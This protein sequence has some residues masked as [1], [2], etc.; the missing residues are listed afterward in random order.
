MSP[1]Q[2]SVFTSPAVPMQSPDGQPAGTW[3]PIACTLI[4]GPQSAVL[5]NT[6]FTTAETASLADWIVRTIPDKT[7]TS[8]YISHGFGD[9][10]LGLPTMRRRFPG[11]KVY[12][13]RLTLELMKR[14]ME[15]QAFSSFVGGFPGLI[16]EQPSTAEL[17]EVLPANNEIN[18]DGEVL[19]AITV[20]Q[21]AVPHSTILWVPSLRL[22]V[23]GT[24][25]YGD[26][27]QMLANVAN[28]KG[29]QAWIKSIEAVEALN[30][31]SVVPSHMKEGEIPGLCHLS[32]TK[33]YIHVFDGLISTGKVKT[34]K[35]LIAAMLQR[36]PNRFNPGA[37]IVS[38]RAAFPVK[39]KM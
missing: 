39:S 6:P 32:N 30:P 20:G 3:S 9:F 18:L 37:L 1:L 25:A 31:M 4:H 26:V 22:A 28:P 36:Y 7:L 27:H 11:V 24:V 23:C 35:E 12:A 21:A 33:E 34:A 15:S 14:N 17:A 8:I 5:I 10:F 38:S 2:A 29:R 16:D 13:T 19:K